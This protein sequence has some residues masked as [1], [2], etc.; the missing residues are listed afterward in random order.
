MSASTV[1]LQTTKKEKGTARRSKARRAG[2]Q[3]SRTGKI[4]LKIF[5][6]AIRDVLT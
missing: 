2:S 6:E 4:D 3:K 1:Y 5:L